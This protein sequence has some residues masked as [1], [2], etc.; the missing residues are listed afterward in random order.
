MMSKCS[1]EMPKSKVATTPLV[2]MAKRLVAPSNSVS[3]P[4]RIF[5]A[6]G[7]HFCASLVSAAG[8]PKEA[9]LRGR[10]SFKSHATDIEQNSAAKQQ[11]PCHPRLRHDNSLAKVQIQSAADRL[12]LI[13][14]GP[15]L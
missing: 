2:P 14:P 7:P 8:L 10:A 9:C 11:Q 1:A 12:A 6:H 4:V 15:A 5:P 13:I 3:A